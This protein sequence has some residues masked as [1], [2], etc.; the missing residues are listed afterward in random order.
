MPASI[1]PWLLRRSCIEPESID[2]VVER[3]RSSSC[4]AEHA[5]EPFVVER[6]SER[7][8][9]RHEMSGTHGWARYEGDLGEAWSS[10]RPPAGSGSER[11]SR[12]GS[13]ATT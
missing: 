5:F 1:G 6:W 13:G 11:A 10:S 2:D 8:R 9:K 7:Q 3:V 12:S 4:T